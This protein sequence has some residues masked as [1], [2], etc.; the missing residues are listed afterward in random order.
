[1]CYPAYGV[2]GKTDKQVW[3]R[4]EET[5]VMFRVIEL[6]FNFVMLYGMSFFPYNFE[7]TPT[8]IDSDKNKVTF[9]V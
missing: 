2:R 8:Y 1:M 5:H 3:T 4:L 9:T 7:W 6:V